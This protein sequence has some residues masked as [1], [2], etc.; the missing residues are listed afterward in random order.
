MSGQGM[1]G[2][3]LINGAKYDHQRIDFSVA[4]GSTE[5]WVFENRTEMLHPMHVHAGQFHIVSR[6]GKPP[7]PQEA[8][9]KDVVLT[10]PGEVVEVR[11]TFPDYQ[12]QSM[13]PT[14][15]IAISSSMKMPA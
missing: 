14:C 6:N 3:L 13:R 8:G 2:D 12:R 7:P 10:H 1:M 4:A 15:C 11:M 9:L 5:T